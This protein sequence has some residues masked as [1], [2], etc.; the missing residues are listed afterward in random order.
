M[1]NLAAV[2]CGQGKYEKAEEMLRRTLKLHKTI[3]GARHPRTLSSMENLATVLRYQ[4]K[5]DAVE[6][7]YQRS[8]QE[9]F[10]A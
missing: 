4:G 5:I 9:N 6:E 10:P 8:K 7:L 1:N 2:L 3:L